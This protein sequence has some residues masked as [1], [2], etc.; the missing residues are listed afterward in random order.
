MNAPSIIENPVTP[1]TNV[2]AEWYTH[3]QSDY[4]FE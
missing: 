3:D 4:G 1:G 2:D